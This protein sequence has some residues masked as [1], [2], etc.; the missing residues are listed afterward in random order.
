MSK[1]Q[2]FDVSRLPAYR[3]SYLERFHPYA[4]VSTRRTSEM[5]M[6]TVDY[7]HGE[8]ATGGDPAPYARSSERCEETHDTQASG[9]ED[10]PVVDAESGCEVPIEERLARSKLADALL[11]LLGA[12]RT[13][14][15]TMQAVQ[16]FLSSG[17]TK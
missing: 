13:R 2:N 11:E 9:Y 8:A 1:A 3:K 16:G 7:R 10:P 17:P 14:Y 5:L 4:R 6:T 15:L 12:L